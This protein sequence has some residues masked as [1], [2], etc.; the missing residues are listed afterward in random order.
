[1]ASDYEAIRCDNRLRY[2]TD[3]GRIG[4]M[5]LSDRYDDRTH[6]ISELLQNAEDALARRTGLSGPRAV[7]FTLADGILR[8]SHYGKPFDEQDVRGICGI[9]D[10]TK[11]KAAIG[12][13]GIGFKSVFA[14]TDRP[15]IHS[16][17]EEFVIENF[18][19]PATVPGIDRSADE[20]V[21]IL[22]LKTQDGAAYQEITRGL[23]RLGARTL[24]FL[25]QVE[26]IEWNVLGGPSGFYIRSSPDWADESVRR[27]TVIGQ[28]EGRK[29]IE[30]TWLIFSRPIIGNEGV[31]GG[32]V[33]AAFSIAQ[34]DDSG[35]EVVR[36]VKSSPLVV[37]FP[38]VLETHLG[39]LLQGPYRTTPSRDNVP[40]D[41]QWNQHC[42]RES[43]K[44]LRQ[45]LCWLRDHDL[46]DT[47]ALRCLPLDSAKF[48]QAAMFAPVFQ[49]T[50]H[51]L[52]SV[53]LLPRFDGGYVAAP[54]A[55]LA[56]TQELRALLGPTQLAALFDRSEN[57]AWLSGEITADRTPE[58]RQY[59]IRELEIAEVTPESMLSR[60]DAS[61]LEAQPDQWILKLYEFLNGQPSLRRRLKEQPLV[62]LNDGTHVVGHRDGRPM[63]F[64]PGK[65]ETDFPTVRATVCS[66]DAAREFLRSLGLTEPDPVDDVIWNILP[67]YRGDEV[68][69]RDDDYEADI[70]RIVKAFATDSKGQREK[71]LGALRGTRFVM[72]V[73]VGAGSKGFSTPGVVYLATERLKDLFAGVSDVLL[74]DDTYACL[75]GEDTRELLEACGATRYLQPIAVDASF[76]WEELREI[77]IAAGCES[78]SA[79]DSIEDRT[80]RG[81][82]GVLA[83][84]PHLDAPERAK[85]AVLL[86]EA[87]G[88]LEDRRGT[89]VFSGA[90]RW[91]YVQ[92]RSTTFDAAFVRKLNKIAWVPDATGELQRP[93]FILFESLGWKTN[94]FLQSKI[95]FKPP[96]IDQLAKEVGIEPGVLDLLK[97]LGVT[98]EGELRERLGL[99][100]EPESEHEPE[101]KAEGDPGDVADAVS[102][103]LGDA[104]EPTPPVPDVM[105]SEPRGSAGHTGTSRTDRATRSNDG[106]GSTGSGT[107]KAAGGRTPASE[108]AA[109]DH[110]PAASGRRPFISYVGAHPDQEE[111]DP[112]GL[113][114]A[115]RMALEEQAIVRIL[116]AE[117][118][119][120]RTPAHNPG[121]DLFEPAGEGQPTRLIEV[122]AMTGSLNDRPVGL[123]HTQFAYAQQHGESYW[124]YV[125]EHAG[126]D[127]AAIVRIQDPAGKARTFT[128]DRGWREVAQVE[129]YTNKLGAD[130]NGKDRSH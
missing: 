38:T 125:I 94:P 18:V 9:A 87:L 8:V 111:P 36:P 93:E 74:V 73:G 101:S 114:K 64:L 60:L 14:F 71:L 29:D 11:D 110:G 100:V 48:S 41:D 51:T 19:W 85:K 82:D 96:L 77:R 5:L 26:E 72:A 16:G 24:L 13:F 123:S 1:M 70:R 67:R 92:R 43:A 86:W 119:L 76:S 91:Y 65:T 66:T 75:R 112:D 84:L 116:R 10:S 54:N 12:R 89:G 98:S 61:F 7:Q 31:A 78:I 45:A 130:T 4:P 33:E 47:G 40:R 124:L 69:V 3:I 81:L 115:A 39:F 49:E 17:A 15:E 42:V 121:F 59:L 20:T 23:Q 126:E 128:F 30:E 97:K 106:G 95:R 83:L 35:R 129:G 22:P 28:E 63:A 90:Y 107:G 127:R 80:L 6:F 21:I 2:G 44:L 108:K 68:D 37:Y 53:P 25:R 99:V 105:G 120:Q 104:P 102:K 27:I 88:D 113:E 79:T 32:Q 122:K 58:L 55:R 62:R 50:K 117:P 56:R 57:L 103:L 46:L 52:R 109:G 118:G 34:Q